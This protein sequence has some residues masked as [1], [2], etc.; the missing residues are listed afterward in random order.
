MTKKVDGPADDLKKVLIQK[1][2]VGHFVENIPEDFSKRVAYVWQGNGI[3]EVRKLVLGTFTTHIHKFDVPGLNKTLKAGWTLNVP[4][5]PA[6]LLDITLSFFRQIHN[7][8]SSE[9]FLQYFYDTKK[10]EYI[11]HCPQQIVGPCSVNYKR[12]L[13]YEKGK[14]LVFEI[15]S[16]GTMGAFFS[17]TDDNDEKDDRFFGVIGHV[18]NY[19]PELKMR[20]SVGG[21]KQ[22]IEMDDIFNLDGSNYY[23]ESFP[24]DWAN[25]IKEKKVKIVEKNNHA[26]LWNRPCRS[27]GSVYYPVDELRGSHRFRRDHRAPG[28]HVTVGCEQLSTDEDIDKQLSM[29]T[30]QDEW[31]THTYKNRINNRNIEA[32]LQTHSE[33]HV[34]EKLLNDNNVTDVDIM[35]NLLETHEQSWDDAETVSCVSGL[36]NDQ[37]LVEKDGKTYVVYNSDDTEIWEEIETVEKEEVENEQSRERETW[38][39]FGEEILSNWRDIKW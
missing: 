24:A 7:K 23:T 27:G 2:L 4:K 6:T 33:P 16:H 20:L 5:I 34:S 19:Y 22:D 10:E 21:R 37:S 28:R 11:L 29:F 12:D 3:W 36:R 30:D 14:I 39:G 15:H 38:E 26:D 9:V 25:C 18:K 8:H 13:D 17:G 31:L 32:G 35:R 1:L